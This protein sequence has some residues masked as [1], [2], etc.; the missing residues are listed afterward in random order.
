M[1]KNAVS[2]VRYGVAYEEKSKVGKLK[3]RVNATQDFRRCGIMG[4][5]PLPSLLVKYQVGP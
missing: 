2:E 1:D 5:L 3:V 4:P